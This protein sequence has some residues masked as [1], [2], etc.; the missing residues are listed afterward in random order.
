MPQLTGECL[1]Y[2]IPKTA[3]AYEELSP[4]SS[5]IHEILEES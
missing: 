2:E 3:E 5:R 1:W 4:E